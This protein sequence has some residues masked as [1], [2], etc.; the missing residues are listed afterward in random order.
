MPQRRLALLVTAA[1]VLAAAPA[2]ADGYFHTPLDLDACDVIKT[3]EA[4]GADLRCDG[5]GGFDVFVSEGDARTDVDFGVNNDRFQ[6]FSAFNGIGQT[7]EWLETENG[8]EAATIRFLIDVDG[9]KAQALVVS[10]IGLADTPGCVVGIVDAAVE[11]AN[12]VAR[13]LAALAPLFD[14]A[15]DPIAIVPGANDLVK[16]FSG[17]QQ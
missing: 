12:G 3:Y 17:A 4:G 8:V 13:G 16:D 7:V 14:C 9:R 11:Q 1:L 10:K 6:T 15:S 5:Y 2:R